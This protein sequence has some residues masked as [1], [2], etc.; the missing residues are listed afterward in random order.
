MANLGPLS[1]CVPMRT[2]SLLSQWRTVT[3]TLL[4]GRHHYFGGVRT[5][6]PL[7]RLT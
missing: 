6:Y 3:R 7:N 1:S 2:L 5:L 4:L